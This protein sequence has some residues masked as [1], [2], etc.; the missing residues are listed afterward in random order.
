[1]CEQRKNFFKVGHSVCHKIASSLCLYLLSITITK[2]CLFAQK[3]WEKEEAISIQEKG[4]HVFLLTFWVTVKKFVSENKIIL[5]CIE[6]MLELLFKY[7]YQRSEEFRIPDFV[8][9]YI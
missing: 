8:I 4:C 7:L 1:M 5:M 9:L 2:E 3:K 6:K